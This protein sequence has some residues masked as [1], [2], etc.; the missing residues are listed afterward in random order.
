MDKH[1]IFCDFFGV[2][3]SEIAPVWLREYLPPEAAAREKERIFRQADAG[4]ISEETSFEMLS[5]LTGIPVPRIRREWDGL[6]RI[7]AGLVDLLAELKKEHRVYLLSNAVAPYLRR[8]LEKHDLYRLFD[9]VFI[10]S[11]MHRIKPDPEYFRS[12]LDALGIRGRDAVMIDDN[13]ENIR[14]AEAAGIRGIVYLDNADLKEKLT[15][16]LNG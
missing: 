13:S 7:N 8:I 16:F 3:S 9:E 6:L 2:I 1:M 12:V 4:E 15:A 14:G 10:S 5:E 11:E